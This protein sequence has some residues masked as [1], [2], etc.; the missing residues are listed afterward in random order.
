MKK[1]LLISS[2]LASTAA[3][4]SA[5][6]G[7]ADHLDSIFFLP[8]EGKTVSTTTYTNGEREFNDGTNDVE[9]SSNSITQEFNHGI[10][11]RL[12]VNL[13]I[14]Y[15]DREIEE[16]ASE[17]DADGFTNPDLTLTYRVA[18][19]EQDGFFADIRLGYSPDL[20]DREE[21]TNADQDGT[22]ASGN[23]TYNVGVSYGRTTDLLAYKLNFDT[24]YN[25]DTEI[26]DGSSNLTIDAS[27]DFTY[28]VDVQYVANDHFSVTAGVAKTII[29]S[30]T[31]SDGNTR[32]G[33]N[34]L[35]LDLALNYSLNS[36][37]LFTVAYNHA[38]IDDSSIGS[39]S[40]R[41]DDEEQ[42][43]TAAVAFRF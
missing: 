18:N 33:G 27:T 24:T 4:N 32:E 5:N 3:F 19:E 42:Q 28:G 16:G 21:P 41:T 6:A 23:D 22:V 13:G 31:D 20:F 35:D 30:A 1:V 17:F 37:L 9:V 8:K 29:G 38:E 36:D 11:E 2:I 39:S 40:T 10:N 25:S 14:T 34:R 15:I 43:I 7:H 12:A 26:E